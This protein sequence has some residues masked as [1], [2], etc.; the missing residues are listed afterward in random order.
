MV[1]V[2]M[3]TGEVE[4][5]EGW[6]VGRFSQEHG[7]LTWHKKT[8]RQTLDE[9]QVGQKVKLWPNHS[10]ITASHFGWYFVVD[11]SRQGK[12]DEIVDIFVRARGW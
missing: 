1:P 8:G 10:C 11:H 5:Y 3:P 4:E 9:L 12:E 7:I 6:I 2:E